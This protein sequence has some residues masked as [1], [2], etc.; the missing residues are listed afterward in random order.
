MC[1]DFSLK[2][3]YGVNSP[4]EMDSLKHKFVLIQNKNPNTIEDSDIND[5]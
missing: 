5:S 2:E 1:L 3:N 4:G